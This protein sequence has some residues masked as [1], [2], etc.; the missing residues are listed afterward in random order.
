[1]KMNATMNVS[2]NGWSA[3]GMLRS[4][5]SS[6]VSL[7]PDHANRPHPSQFRALPCSPRL[8][9]DGATVARGGIVPEG[10]GGTL[11]HHPLKGGALNQANIVFESH[12]LSVAEKVE[13][14]TVF[15]APLDAERTSFR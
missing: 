14:V 9:H 10:E 13:V 7:G 5:P 11:L 6:L 12:L 4:L 15:P 1:M 8:S 2:H 3:A